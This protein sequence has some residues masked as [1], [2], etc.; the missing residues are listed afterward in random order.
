VLFAG[1]TVWSISERVRSVCVDALYKSTFTLLYFTLLDRAVIWHSRSF[2]VNDFC[3]NRKPIYDFLLVINCHLSS[4]SY[5]FRDIASRSRKRPHHSLRPPI[6]GT[7]FEFRR[8]TYPAKSRDL[9][10]LLC[11]KCVIL[12]SVVLSHYTRV[13]DDGQTDDLAR[14]WNATATFGEKSR[15][16]SIRSSVNFRKEHKK[17]KIV[18]S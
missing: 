10:L 9:T 4:I 18:A 11:E 1:N 17:C 2:K 5:R 15:T 6:K 3:C 8:Q 16:L 7:A 14:H 12:T 13:T